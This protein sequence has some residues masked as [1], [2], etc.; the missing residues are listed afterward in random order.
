MV[1]PSPQKNPLSPLGVITDFAV[2][3]LAGSGHYRPR[4]LVVDKDTHYED[5]NNANN[6]KQGVMFI[7][8]III[9]ILILLP[10]LTVHLNQVKL[11]LA[12]GMPRR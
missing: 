8:I 7:H 2:S 1:F 4:F 11:F 9:P 10:A 12:F 3:G 5:K 6:A